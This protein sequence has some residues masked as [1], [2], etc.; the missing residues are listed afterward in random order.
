M[1]FIN[2]HCFKTSNALFLR[3]TI[4][5]GVQRI[6]S[7]VNDIF[8]PA[9]R[10]LP[11]VAQTVASQFGDSD[12][13]KATFDGIV[14]ASSARLNQS[15]S[16]ALVPVTLGQERILSPFKAAMD[17]IQIDVQRL[18][19]QYDTVL[20]NFQHINRTAE[21]IH[22]HLIISSSLIDLEFVSL[23]ANITASAAA[24]IK[25]VTNSVFAL[26][27]SLFFSMS[28]DMLKA[29]PCSNQF[30]PIV[31]NFATS[32]VVSMGE[33]MISEI[34]TFGR[35]FEAVIQTGNLLLAEV[36]TFSNAVSSC[37]SEITSSSSVTENT[38]AN[39]CL[40]AVS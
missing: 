40:A 38:T 6:E 9:Q 11:F 14:Q 23:E 22:S 30:I 5:R 12:T 29:I 37:A 3:E 28:L 1:V 15:L 21:T 34:N 19:A 10:E 13:I 39:E 33:C 32:A 7:V 27:N 4:K 26:I 24:G 25:N 36:K 8:N 2:I 16:S 20:S 35:D 18:N 17:V 31:Q